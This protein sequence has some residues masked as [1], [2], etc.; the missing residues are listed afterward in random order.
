LMPLPKLAWQ[1]P[2]PQRLRRRD[3]IEEDLEAL[4]GKPPETPSRTSR[5]SIRNRSCGIGDLD[6]ADNPGQVRGESAYI[7]TRGVQSADSAPCHIPAADHQIH[8]LA[9]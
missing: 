6:F 5:R 2:D 7:C 4:A 1:F 8:P 3:D 9:F